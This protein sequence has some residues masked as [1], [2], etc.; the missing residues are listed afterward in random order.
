MKVLKS[1]ISLI[2]WVLILGGLLVFVMTALYNRTTLQIIFADPVVQA[3]FNILLRLLYCVIAFLI[4]LIFLVIALRINF[5]I[6]AKE[7]EQRKQEEKRR[8]EEEWEEERKEL[9]KEY[10]EGDH[11]SDQ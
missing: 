7:R 5:N 2:A 4:G 3:S 8:K 11:L 6:K 1:I 9:L 10:G